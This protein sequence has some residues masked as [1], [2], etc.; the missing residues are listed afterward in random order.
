MSISLFVHLMKLGDE[1]LSD[2]IGTHLTRDS[3]QV[4][5]A[6]RNHAINN[7][8]K[9]LPDI[10]INNMVVSKFNL[11]QFNIPRLQMITNQTLQKLPR[12]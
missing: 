2:G 3:Q 8:E 10:V 7:M 4:K 6:T 9:T 12:E 1:L 5:G 11:T